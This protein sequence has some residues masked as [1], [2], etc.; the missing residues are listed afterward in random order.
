[1]PVQMES[2]IEIVEPMGADT[3]AWTK[4]AGQSLTFRAA[5]EVHLEPGQKVL[6]GFDPG[7]GSVF[8]AASGN[9]I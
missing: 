1:M 5:A 3:V 9:R 4:I 8:N 2:E 7:R 6:I